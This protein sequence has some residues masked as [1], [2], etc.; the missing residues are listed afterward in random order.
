MCGTEGTD[1][2]LCR[3]RLERRQQL[4]APRGSL[5]LLHGCL[6]PPLPL[7]PTF[8]ASPHSSVHADSHTSPPLTFRSLPPYLSG[9]PHL[10]AP[11]LS[12][13][14]LKAASPHSSLL[15][16]L[17]TRPPRLHKTHLTFQI[18]SGHNC[19]PILLPPYLSSLLHLLDPCIR[20]RSQ[21]A[22]SKLPPPIP[23]LSQTLQP[24]LPASTTPPSPSPPFPATLASA[25]PSPLSPT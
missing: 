14:P 22:L 20:R 13:I 2:G 8:T 25:H 17:T 6:Q 9:L 15:I 10:P 12:A 19:L 24:T 7:P 3:T 23:S 1:R 11:P 5:L 21:L 4:P 16:N 18:L